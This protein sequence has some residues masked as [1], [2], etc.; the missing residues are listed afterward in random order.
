MSISNLYKS[1]KSKY[2]ELNENNKEIANYVLNNWNDID[3]LT[4][5]KI[6]TYTNQSASTIVRFCKIFSY[7]GFYDFRKSIL[8]INSCLKINNNELIIN[9]KN[10]DNTLAFEKKYQ[11]IEEKQ[12]SSIIELIK[13][14][15][16]DQAAKIIKLSNKVI[17]G[18]M[19][20]NYNQS[21]DFKNKLLAAGKACVVEQDVHLLKSLSNVVSK[22]DLVIS[23]SL[24]NKNDSIIKFG[25]ESKWN[26]ANWIHITSGIIFDFGTEKPDLLVNFTSEENKLWNLYS[27]RGMGLF[28]ILNLIFFSF[29]LFQKNEKKF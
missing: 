2:S 29:I 16:I 28:K 4:I 15:T 19:N 18:G 11:E 6:S 5:K 22:N 9:T 12:Q 1:I 7:K 14:G 13:N 3:K 21:V 27:I 10:I 25:K 23:I 26:G 24:S 8:E 17:I 20:I